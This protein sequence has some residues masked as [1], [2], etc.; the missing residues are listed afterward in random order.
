MKKLIY[1]VVAAL[2]IVATGCKKT[3]SGN[4]ELSLNITSISA[5]ADGMEA[6]ILFEVKNGVPG[7]SKVSSTSLNAGVTYIPYHEGEED[8]LPLKEDETRISAVPGAG[9]GDAPV[10][11]LQGRKVIDQKAGNVYIINHKKILK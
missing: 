7:F 11:D 6:S 4:P 5:P 9:A 3:E 10:Y 8:F 1:V 2:L